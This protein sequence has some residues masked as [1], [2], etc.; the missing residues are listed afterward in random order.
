MKF[1]I[2]YQ[3]IDEKQNIG[4]KTGKEFAVGFDEYGNSYSVY[5]DGSSQFLFSIIEQVNSRGKA[6]EEI[7]MNSSVIKQIPYNE[8]VK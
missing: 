1:N 7:F 8:F 4:L 5:R 6:H 3:A 2:V